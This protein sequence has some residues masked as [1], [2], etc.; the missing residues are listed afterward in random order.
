[1]I[2]SKTGVP[3]EEKRSTTSVSGSAA[4]ECTVDRGGGGGGRGGRG[5]GGIGGGGIIGG[6]G[7]EGGDGGGRGGGGPWVNS[8]RRDVVPVRSTVDDSRPESSSIWMCTDANKRSARSS[9]AAAAAAAVAGGTFESS[10]G[11]RSPVR[12]NSTGNRNIIARRELAKNRSDSIGSGC[13][14]PQSNDS[15]AA[16]AAVMSRGADGRGVAGPITGGDKSSKT[17]SNGDVSN[18][19]IAAMS[20]LQQQ[21]T[22]GRHRVAPRRNSITVLPLNSSLDN[23]LGGFTSLRTSWGD[24]ASSGESVDRLS[25]SL[26]AATEL[27]ASLIGGGGGGG[28]SGGGGGGNNKKSETSFWVPPTVWK[29]KRAMS[30]APQVYSSPNTFDNEGKKI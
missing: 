4:G 30:L 29:R 19:N 20:Q 6:E 15:I 1:M 10:A 13:S 27:V 8:P 23:E 25:L 28:S 16:A 21:E 7:G 3:L 9:A 12:N 2:A 26:S 5:G 22:N 18:K 14:N 24:T 11:Y 17:T